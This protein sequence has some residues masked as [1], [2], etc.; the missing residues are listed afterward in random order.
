MS[1][2]A[3]SGGMS[4]TIVYKKGYSHISATNFLLKRMPPPCAS[5][6]PIGGG[7]HANLRYYRDA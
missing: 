7:A 4:Q 5:P 2:A 3:I 6:A 1:M